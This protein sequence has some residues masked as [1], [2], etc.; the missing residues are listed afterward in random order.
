M[1]K[2]FTK[3]ALVLLA[4]GLT[5]CFYSFGWSQYLSFDSLKAQQENLQAFY[6]E[7][8][9]L[10]LSAY[11]GIYIVVTALSFPGAT[12]LTLAGG[13]IFGFGTGLIL[14]SFASTIGATLAFLFTRFL[15][16]D[17]L[18]R[19]FQSQLNTIN[20]GLK[21]DGAFYLF[22]LR[23]VPIFPFFLINLLMGLT[24]MRTLTFFF[25]SQVGMLAGT[26]VYVNAGTQIGQLKSLDGILSPIFI[27]SFV[28]LGLVP[29]IAKAFVGFIASYRLY[30]TFQ[31]SK[32]YD[33]NFVFTSTIATGLASIV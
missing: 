10:L 17:F 15:L 9:L 2:K 29:W 25:I 12:I 7:N 18:E 6:L 31:K 14:V 24:Q 32:K 11:C 19:K 22:A 26:A 23:L 30:K 4:L 33:Y 16:R 5:W 28:A 13:A 27:L 21:K 3:I 1:L 8:T 20:K